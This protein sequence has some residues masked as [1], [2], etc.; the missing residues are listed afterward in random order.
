MLQPQSAQHE[1]GFA[2]ASS[3]NRSKKSGLPSHPVL[4]ELSRPDFRAADSSGFV[5][6]GFGFDSNSMCYQSALPPPTRAIPGGHIAS[7]ISTGTLFGASAPPLPPKSDDH[8]DLL[9]NTGGLFGVPPPPP[10]PPKSGDHIAS[11]I[12]TRTLFGASAPPLPPKSDDHI[13][14]LVNTRGLFG[15]PPPPP[16]RPKSGDHIASSIN[17]GTLFGASAPPLPPK[18]DDHI[19]LLV[20]T[21]ALFGAPPPP[22][23]PPPKSR[24]HIAMSLNTGT[25]LRGYSAPP[26]PPKPG[27][28]IASS[29]NT[30]TLSRA[31]APPLPL[32]S[33]DHIAFS[34][35]SQVSRSRHVDQSFNTETFDGAPFSFV[36]QPSSAASLR[37]NVY[38]GFTH[39]ELDDTD[40]V[41]LGEND[42]FSTNAEPGVSNRC[43]REERVTYT[44]STNIY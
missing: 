15:A 12:N 4:D 36:D 13:D 31:S 28:H 2:F 3:G 19:N 21:G 5:T 9:V 18:S 29:L 14:L 40:E 22:P 44:I 34:P 37:S 8:I 6:Q 32:E 42:G 33:G 10:P 38:V 23:P 1:V 43:C 11:S 24:D 26:P 16:P 20:N 35:L 27:D 39:G 25:A 41:T 7:S 30:G 17:T